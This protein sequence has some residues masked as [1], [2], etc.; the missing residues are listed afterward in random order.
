MAT[1]DLHMHTTYSDGQ[2][3]ARQLLNGARR[4]GLT[5][6]AITDH[7]TGQ[8]SRDGVSIAKELG[9]TLI[10][11]IEITVSWPGYTGHGGGP[12]IDLLGY[13]IDLDSPALQAHEQSAL[14]AYT[15]RAARV[16]ASV[17]R[18]RQPVVVEDVLETHPTYPGY[19]ALIQTLQ[20]KGLARSRAEGAALIEPAWRAEGVLLG[21][22]EAIAR[23]HAMG[24]VA[25]LAHPAIIHR[26]DGELLNERGLGKLIEMGLDGIEVLHYR[27]NPQQRRHFALLAKMFRLPITG[28]SDEHGGPEHFSRLGSEPV[29]QEM[30][31][32]L[33]ER[34]KARV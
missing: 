6:V 16:A 29:T 4:K 24:G 19:L 26:D 1:V 27:N 9:L 15:E 10:P 17:S 34:R 25:V 32:A 31:S 23:I 21:P 5:T 18:V 7:E 3:S 13:F 8:G 12:D 33:S 2:A 20:R 11:A 14:N 28:G 30:V 22:E